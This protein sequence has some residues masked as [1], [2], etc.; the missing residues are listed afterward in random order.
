MQEPATTELDD[1]DVLVCETIDP[2]RVALF[3]S[4]GR[5]DRLWGLVEP[6]PDRGP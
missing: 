3:S 4:L 6:R 2:S 5:G 1:G